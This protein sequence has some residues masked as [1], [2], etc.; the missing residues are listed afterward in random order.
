VLVR[1]LAPDALAATL[2]EHPHARFPVVRE[3]RLLG[4]L[5]REEAA[6]ACKEKRE[7]KLEGLATCQPK[8]SIRRLQRLLIDSTTGLVALVDR[9]GGKVI[10]LVTLH[11]LLRAQTQV[12]A[13]QED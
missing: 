10:G 11:D 4:L 8:D 12:A 1:D 7:P 6:E 3:R 13:A 2:R 9:P 5:T